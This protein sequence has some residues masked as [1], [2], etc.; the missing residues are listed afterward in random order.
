MT[1]ET[2]KNKLVKKSKKEKTE[3]VETGKEKID[4][5]KSSVIENKSEE[6]K[7]EEKKDSKPKKE[8]KP[9]VHKTE[10]VVLGR[11][12]PI[13]TKHS[14]ALCRFVKGKTPEKAI[15]H[16]EL[17]KKKKMAVPMKGEIPHR[18][19]NIMSG[20]YPISASEYFINLLKTLS[21][22][23]KVNGLDDKLKITLAKANF[24]P[25]P[26]G[27]FGAHQKKRTHVEIKIIV[28]KM[29]EKK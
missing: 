14:I 23:A 25:R 5:E 1:E 8:D 17:V 27:R 3:I 4:E 16:L 28:P 19:G 11:N 12:L 18:K 29:E 10:A 9:K 20:R 21:A 13:S 26:Y 6:T 7:N 2:Q 22:N 24:A 15:K